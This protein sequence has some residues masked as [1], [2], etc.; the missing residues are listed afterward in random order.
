[1]HAWHCLLF[2]LQGDQIWRTEIATSTE[3]RDDPPYQIT[4]PYIGQNHVTVQ[5]S[6]DDAASWYSKRKRQLQLELEINQEIIIAHG[7]WIVYWFVYLCILV[8]QKLLCRIQIVYDAC[9]IRFNWIGLRI[10][11]DCYSMQWTDIILDRVITSY[12]A[13]A[14]ADM[15]W[16]QLFSYLGQMLKLFANLLN[17]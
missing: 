11:R 5:W 8:K 3:R 6:R 13:T 14:W 7:M 2:N 15:A 4:W 10:H 9:A 1:M 12:Q 17:W 16:V